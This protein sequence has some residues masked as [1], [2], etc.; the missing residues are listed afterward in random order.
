MIAEL[1]DAVATQRSWRGVMRVLG[2]TTSR[3]GRALRD[4]C[5]EHRI[6]YSHF[7]RA[8]ADLRNLAA[9][10]DQ[11]GTWPDLLERLGY[12]ANSGTARATIRKHCRR[13]GI[14]TEHLAPQAVPATVWSQLAPS[15]EHLRR[16]GPHIVAAALT[17]AGLNVCAAGEGGAYDLLVDE[18]AAGVKR[19]QVKTTTTKAGPSWQCMLTR[20][21]YS[22]S[23]A[24][25]H[26]K[27]VYSSEQVDYFA[28]VSQDLR[29]YL[30]PIAEVEG[31]TMISLRKYARYRVPELPPDVLPVGRA[32]S[33]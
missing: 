26:R 23:G 21:E 12:A 24:G 7:R 15:P 31:L 1:A 22:R 11:V 16:A 10:V 28:C 19:V 17:L 14:A 20:K 27:A 32:D 33:V 2:F 9:V 13:M 3:S 30:I 25:G 4:I 6:D 5:D 8:R 18:G 29:V